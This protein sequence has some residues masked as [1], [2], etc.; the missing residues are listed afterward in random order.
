MGVVVTVGAVMT[1]GL[2]ASTRRATQQAEAGGVRACN[3]AV[4]RCDLALNQVV[5]PGTHN[6]M[7][8]ALYPGWLFGEQVNTIR[9]QLHSGI[10]AFLIDT[11]YGV[12][13]SARLPGS[14][15]PIVLTDQTA[16]VVAQPGE[17]IDPAVVARANQLAARSPKAANAARG[18]YLCHNYCELGAVSFDS[19]LG[20]VKDFLDTNPND[21]VI[22]DIQDATSPADTAAAI[23][24]AGL[25]DRVATLRE[26][27][28]L[29]TLG[30]LIDAGTTLLVFAE[31]GG[32]GGPPWYHQMYEWFQETPYGYP[33]IEAFDC[34]PNRGTAA[35][36]MLLVNHWVSKKGLADPKAARQANAHEVLR[37]RRSAA[38]ASA[39]SCPTSSPSTSEGRVTS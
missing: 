15:A 20:D 8:S 39:G 14:G 28:P 32:A 18:I 2:V 35:S 24:R 30:E 11:H 12:P 31:V 25:A 5:F 27:E 19:V 37:A 6:S 38:C 22:L 23:E 4:N 26:G 9:A 10:R 29:P 3:G 16:G 17:E 13:S 1:V 21:V 7:S 33:S 34:S 36:P